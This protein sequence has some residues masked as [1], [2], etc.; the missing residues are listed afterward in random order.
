MRCSKC[1]SNFHAGSAH[2]CQIFQPSNVNPRLFGGIVN[3]R[4]SHRYLWQKFVAK[5]QR[6]VEEKAGQLRAISSLSALLAGFAIV[7]FLEM[8]FTFDRPQRVPQYRVVLPLHG[9]TTGTTVGCN[10][11]LL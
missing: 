8:Q 11:R 6:E 1:P 4:L 10:P 2:S 3:P 9:L 5:N 7:A